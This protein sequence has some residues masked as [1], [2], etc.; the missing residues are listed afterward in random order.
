[1]EQQQL[2]L[3]KYFKSLKYQAKLHRVAVAQIDLNQ[4]NAIANFEKYNTGSPNKIS[5][6]FSEIL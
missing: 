3:K 5:E 2:M 4:D 1:M 6:L